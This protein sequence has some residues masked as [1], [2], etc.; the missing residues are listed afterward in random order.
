MHWYIVQFNMFTFA[1]H[2]KKT[3]FEDDNSKLF[4]L[5]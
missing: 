4:T 1:P 5:N 3:F 2:Q